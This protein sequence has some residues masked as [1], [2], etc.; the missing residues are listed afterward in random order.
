MSRRAR[1]RGIAALELALILPLFLA[2]L[3]FPLFWG[4]AFWH[5][6]VI[7]RAAQDAALYL[8]RLPPVEMRNPA[9]TPE[10]AAVAKAIVDAEMAELAAGPESPLV[11][12]GCDALQCGGFATPAIVNV[13]VQLQMSDIFFST[14]TALDFQLKVN[15][16]TPYLGK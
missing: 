11:T 6:S 2:L 12:V 7:Q 3:M 8:T 5:Y 10:L 14:S 13:G 15:V 16:I 4:R 1:Q 9:R